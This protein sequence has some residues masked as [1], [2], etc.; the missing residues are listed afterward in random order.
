[1]N[2]TVLNFVLIINEIKNENRTNLYRVPRAGRLLY[3]I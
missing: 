3:H 2:A 1:M